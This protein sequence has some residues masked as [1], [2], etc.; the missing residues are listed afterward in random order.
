MLRAAAP[1][2]Y[3]P[4]HPARRATPGWRPRRTA[5]HT[6]ACWSDLD[7][8]AWTTVRLTSGHDLVIGPSG[9]HLIHHRHPARH[10]AECAAELDDL[11]RA[12]T[13][14]RAAVGARYADTVTTAILLPDPRTGSRRRSR[15][16]ARTVPEP[17]AQGVLD[18]LDGLD[19]VL[20]ATRATITHTIRHRPTVLS[21]GQVKHLA[22]QISAL[23]A[24]APGRHA[25]R[26]RW[27]PWT[28]RR[29]RERG[30]PN[31][32]RGQDRPRRGLP[33]SA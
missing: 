3:R 14:L 12:A 25:P 22:T 9:L 27:L 24:A 13:Q 30:E 15:R 8:R 2:H 1:E 7:P 32:V 11:R 26:R 6:P 4:R 28:P 19:G 31:A 18:G 5:E 21:A 10:F 33:R 20:C 17:T 29:N 23:H 16:G